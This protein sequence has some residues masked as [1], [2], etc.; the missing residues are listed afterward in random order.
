[1]RRSLHQVPLSQLKFGSQTGHKPIHRRSWLILPCHNRSLR[2]DTDQRWST[3]HCIVDTAVITSVF[4]CSMERCGSATPA[5]AL[6]FLF[7]SNHIP[8]LDIC[9]SNKSPIKIRKQNSLNWATLYGI[10]LVGISVTYV[11]HYAVSSNF[12]LCIVKY[13]FKFNTSKPTSYHYVSS[14][15]NFL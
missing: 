11:L 7:H 10:K 3:S 15:W 5:P 2:L 12:I 9:K 13:F 4:H 6:L 8:L 1:M 14:V